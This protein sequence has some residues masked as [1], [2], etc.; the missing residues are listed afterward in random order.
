ML[1]K[2]FKIIGNHV[3]EHLERQFNFRDYNYLRN[4]EPFALQKLF[5]FQDPFITALHLYLKSSPNKSWLYYA[6]SCS[7]SCSSTITAG[8]FYWQ[9]LQAALV[10]QSVAYTE[11]FSKEMLNP[12]GNR[13]WGNKWL[14]NR[15]K[16]ASKAAGI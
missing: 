4:T 5:R 14:S 11:L 9:V 13:V 3:I 6:W 15:E 10:W 1:K 16:L 7:E 8:L 12:R 2:S